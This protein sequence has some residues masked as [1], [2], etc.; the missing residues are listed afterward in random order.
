MV[1]TIE[2]SHTV[3]VDESVTPNALRYSPIFNVA[4]RFIDQHV[5]DGRGHR[6]AL[7]HPGGEI[8]YAQLADNGFSVP[9]AQAQESVQRIVFLVGERDKEFFPVA[10]VISK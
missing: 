6:I 9:E 7:R 4:V 1:G 8:T 10:G 5:I 2:Q 3:V